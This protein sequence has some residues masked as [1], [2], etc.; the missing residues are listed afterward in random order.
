MYVLASDIIQ[1]QIQDKASGARMPR[2]NE[3]TF[4]DLEI[5]NPPTQVQE[6]I[7]QNIASKKSEIKS[8]RQKAKENL[9]QAIKEFEQEIFYAA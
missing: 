8:L 1:H 7:A 5:P 6:T 3:T 9:P 4:Y 2:I